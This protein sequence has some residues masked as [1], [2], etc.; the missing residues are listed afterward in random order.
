[1]H[2]Q[3]SDGTSLG[4]KIVGYEFPE[5][6]EAEYDSNWLVIRLSATLP[7]GSWIATHPCLLT[8]E[9]TELANWLEEVARGTAAEREIGFVEPNIWFQVVETP[10]GQRCLRAY[11][12]AECRPPWAFTLEHDRGD[13]FAEFALHELELH[14]AAESLRAQLA[15]YPQRAE[16]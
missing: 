3:G 8:Y 1:M 10:N 13:I 16:Y 11:F 12:G 4:L 15:R 14:R 7:Q 9:V 6:V 5:E 2:L